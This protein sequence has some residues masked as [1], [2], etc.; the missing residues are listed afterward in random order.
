MHIKQVI[1]RGFKTYKD[2]VSL[3]EDFHGGV[4][5]V[6]GFNGSGKSNFFNAILF[7]ISDKYQTLRNETRKA[8]LHEGAGPPV[9]TAFVEIVFDNRDRRMPIDKDEVRMR[10][11]IGVKKDDYFLEGKTATKTEIFSLLESCGFTKSNPYYIV[12]QGKISELTL[13]HDRARLDLIKDISGASVYDERKSESEKILEETRMKQQKTDEIIDVIT[14][15]IKN[16]EEEQRELVEY[17]KLERQRRCLEFELTDRD[18]RT[19]QDKIDQLE[20]EK[21]DASA[22]LHEAQRGALAAREKLSEADAEVQH[23]MANRQRQVAERD[24]TE[25]LRVAR[26]GE[27]TRVR[28]ELEDDKKRADA[29]AKA[30][31]ELHSEMARLEAEIHQVEA[32]LADEHPKFTAAQTE[33]RELAQRKQICEAQREQFVAKQGRKSEYTSV[34][35]RNKALEKEI[36]RRKARKEQSEKML[37]DCEEQIKGAE[38]NAKKAKQEAQKR[39]AEMGRKE[40]EL[41]AKIGPQ[42]QRVSEQLEQTAE[43]RRLLVQQRERIV[44]ERDEAERQITQCQNRIDGT[45]PRAQRN[46]LHEVRRWA[47]RQS[48]QDSIYGTLLENIDVAATYHIAVEATAGNSLF[49]LLVK[50]DEIA[51]QVVSFVRTGNVGSIVCTPLNQVNARAREYP[52]IQGVKPLV[53]VINCPHWAAPSVQQVFGRTVVCSSLELCDKVSRDHGLDCITLDGDKVSSRGTLTGGYQDPSR[54]VRL[55]AS[56][57]M[58]QARTLVDKIA[59]QLEQVEQQGQ[60][61]GRTLE[62]LHGERRTLQ[63]S[64]GQR[65]GEM[66]QAAEAV[67]DAEMQVSRHQEAVSRHM[68]RRDEI[69]SVMAECDAAIEALQAEAKTKSIGDLSASEQQQLQDLTVELTKL[70]RA[71]EASEE[72][73]HQGLRRLRGREQHLQDFLRKRQHELKGELLRDNQQENEEHVQER[74]K[75]LARLEREHQEF[76]DN[77]NKAGQQLSK[78]DHILTQK[79]SERESLVVEDGKLQ[80]D[81]AKHSELLDEATMKINNLVMKKSQADEKLRSLTIVSSDMGKYKSMAEKTIMKELQKTNKELSKFEHVNKK[82]MD[83]YTTFMDQL[84]DLQRKRQE[85]NESRAAIESLIARVDEQKEE[86]MLQT[87][88]QVDLHFRDIFSELVRNGIGKLRMVTQADEEAGDGAAKGRTKGVR[89]EVSFTGQ[90]TSFLT[91]NQLSGGQKTVVAIALI[92]AM[93]RL[94]PA[95]FYLFDEID[96]ALDTQYRSSVAKLIARDAKQAQMVITTFRPE[97]IETADQFYR[98]YQK[99]RVS[100]IECVP[101]HEA[102]RVIEEQTRLEKIDN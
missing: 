70:D 68:E 90:N 32:E 75:I 10:R 80:S 25:R 14:K 39:Q 78:M 7:V 22:K 24:E 67:Q 40:K 88:Q 99:N 37:K 49:N 34:Q 42:L 73:C 87:L 41:D 95:P 38:T 16:L 1:I 97:I 17:Q 96:A 8:L 82:A 2:Q 74:S 20:V 65:K 72:K 93:Q 35:E 15:R 30:R 81:I 33:K 46:A 45:M 92:F 98:V 23:V 85:I 9:T 61:A 13:M 64:R 66:A 31:A 71:L 86:T 53:D 50:D 79:K 56:E 62:A 69:V 101:R 54:F 91:M 59:P 29:G 100:R 26:L 48:L 58:R 102:R 77:L 83:Q 89:I 51:A 43:K 4:N 60:E 6:V 94:E 11:A 76:T 84:Q 52:K 3:A 55:A 44:R 57:R 12:Q 19:S 18:S 63:D 36:S 47:S 28:L 21:R 5:V 27:L